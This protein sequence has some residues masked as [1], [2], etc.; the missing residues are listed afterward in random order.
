MY[1]VG[2]IAQSITLPAM[3]YS[4]HLQPVKIDSDDEGE[5]EDISLFPGEGDITDACLLLLKKKLNGKYTLFKVRKTFAVITHLH[6][7]TI[8]TTTVTLNNSSIRN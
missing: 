5:F 7:N 2:S 1:C 8:N 3:S 6:C 4:S